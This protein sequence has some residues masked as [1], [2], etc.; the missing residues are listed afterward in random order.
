MTKRYATAGLLSERAK[1]ELARRPEHLASVQKIAPL[2]VLPTLNLLAIC[3]AIRN[4][5]QEGACTGEATIKLVEAWEIEYGLKPFVPR[6]PQF[7]YNMSLK[8]QN[9]LGHDVGSTINVAL[10][11]PITYGAAPEALYPYDANGDALVM[12]PQ[13][14]IDAAALFKGK[15]AEI[16]NWTGQT[17]SNAIMAY[18]SKNQMPTS[19]AVGVLSTLFNP[20]DGVIDVGGTDYPNEG[21]N[22]ACFGWI[23][24]FRPGKQ[25]KVLFIIANSWDVTWGIQIAPFSTAGLAYMTQDYV[26]QCATEAGALYYDPPTPQP[27][28]LTAA[29][30]HSQVA[31]GA[32][33][34][35]T[36]TTSLNGKPV[37]NQAVNWT[38]TRPDIGSDTGTWETDA[39][40]QYVATPYLATTHGTIAVN[41]SWQSPDGVTH[42]ATASALW[43]SQPPVTHTYTLAAVFAK[44]SV[45]LSAENT[46]IVTTFEDGQPLAGQSVSVVETFTGEI[47]HRLNVATDANGQFST[48][49]VMGLLGSCDAV[50]T[51]DA[52]DGRKTANAT[53][54]WAKTEGV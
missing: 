19:L 34:P 17:P 36:I 6:S 18:M 35:L 51:W 16:I 27:Y 37:G 54:A 7:N 42:T 45:L 24:D 26:D 23:P 4:Q 33:N 46:L 20:V 47:T 21:H 9:E 31:V 3:S 38:Q 41:L 1:A 10:S 11:I 50:A 22:I 14:V 49:V 25:G 48:T 28:K 2:G 40:G 32:Q 5:L 39:N 13:N 30:A 29:F 53:A 52:P 8:L 44:S 12:P 43:D 15:R